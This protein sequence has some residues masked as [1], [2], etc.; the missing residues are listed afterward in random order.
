MTHDQAIHMWLNAATV[1]VLVGAC[2]Y[3]S[4]WRYME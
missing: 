1:L 2:V 3:A 4:L